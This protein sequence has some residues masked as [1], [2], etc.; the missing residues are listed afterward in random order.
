MALA[1]VCMVGIR[2]VWYAIIYTRSQPLGE[3]G[4]NPL[5]PSFTDGTRGEPVL[6]ELRGRGPPMWR[7]G[8]RPAHTLASCVGCVKL[9]LEVVELLSIV[10]VGTGWAGPSHNRRVFVEPVVAWPHT[11]RW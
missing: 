11:T 9:L 3:V 7:E 4:H 5:E 8:G 10:G 6:V 2:M 1:V